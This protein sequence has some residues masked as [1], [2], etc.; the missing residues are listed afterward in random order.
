MM[1]D[2]NVRSV[3]YPVPVDDKLVKIAL[4]LGRTKRQVFIQ[5]VDYFYKSKKDPLDLNDELLKNALMKNHKDYIGFIRKQE[6]MLLIPIKTEMD[7]MVASQI[8]II[9]RFNSEVLKHN[10]DVLNKQNV[11]EQKLNAIGTVMEVM[12]KTHKSREQLK[13]QFLYILDSYIRS[14]DAFGLMTSGK[15]KEE[16]ISTTKAQV[17]L[18]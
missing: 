15:E 2:I 17:S 1:E 3:R 13:A 12:Q 11:H 6:D 16:L 10:V 18:L 4:K 14:R 7:R 8:K 5:M 9:D